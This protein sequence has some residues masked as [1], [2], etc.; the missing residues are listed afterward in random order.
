M[1]QDRITGRLPAGS[2]PTAVWFSEGRIRKV[3]M[4]P[5]KELDD[6]EIFIAP[7]LIDNQ[8]NGYKGVDFSDPELTVDQVRQT[9]SEMYRMGVTTFLPTL[10]TNPEETLTSCLRILAEAMACEDIGPSIPGIH[11]EGPYISREPGYRGAHNPEWIRLPDLNEFQ[12]L[13][14]AAGGRIIQ[15]TLA[16]ELK[17]A[18][19]FIDRCRENHITIALGHHA[20]PA[21][22]IHL[23]AAKGARISTHLGN[24]CANLIDRHNNILWPQLADDRLMASVIADGHHLSPDELRVLFR[25]KGPDKLVIVS[26]LV[27]FGGL[28]PGEYSWNGRMLTVDRN[29]TV[30]LR[31]ESIFAGATQ[32][33]MTGIMNMM[34]YAGCSLEE[35]VDMVTRI[36]AEL[37]HLYDRGRLEAGIRADMVRFRR[38]EDRFVITETWSTG[39]CVYRLTTGG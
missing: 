4:I 37:N 12:R 38:D 10:I 26:D 9:V 33:L 15:I 27:S 18:I 16:P 5:E 28:V 21:E 13:Q 23:A 29:G 34:G 2:V 35:A 25:V 7:G 30:G 11:L 20:A 1:I 8:V 6:P 31:D 17:G 22:I 14:T 3:E 32:S 39:K 36:P 24:A 19:E